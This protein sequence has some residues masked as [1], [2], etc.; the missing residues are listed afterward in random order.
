MECLLD[1]NIDRKLSTITLDNCSTNNSLIDHVMCEIPSSTL[2]LKGKLFHMPCCA[3]IL[4]IIVKDGLKE[5]DEANER[6]RDSVAYWTATQKREEKFEE[7]ARQLDISLGKKLELDCITRWNSTY[8][9][10]ETAIAYK[11]VFPRLRQREPHYKCLPNDDDWKIGKEICGKLKVFYNVT[12]LFSGTKYPTANLYFPQVCLIKMQITEWFG[13]GNEVIRRMASK[14]WPKFEKYWDM[15]HGLMGVATVLDPRYKMQLLEYYFPLLYGSEA[16]KELEMVKQICYDLLS[17][18][19]TKTSEQEAGSNMGTTMSS[20]SHGVDSLDA[21][22]SGFDL[23]VKR[24]QHSNNRTV[25]SELDYYLEEDVLPRT[26]NFEI[27]NWWK[28]SGLKYPT[29]QL[30]ARDVLAIPVSIVA[31]ESAFSTS[32]RILSAHRSRL[33]PE[34]LE[35]LM[36][37]RNW[38]WANMPGNCLYANFC[39]FFC[40]YIFCLCSFWWFITIFK[41]IR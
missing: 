10:L 33:Q 19:Q 16:S 7:A 22:L 8:K 32:G 18:Y 31:S 9:M 37:A 21:A 28:S 36:C 17:E 30:I 24:N 29:L 5:I 11:D 35:A 20:F 4:N 2:M 3:H 25:K 6:I 15:I 23:F 40:I 12:E 39:K 38:L 41:L 26:E 14:M 1:W 13:S 34:I 27:L